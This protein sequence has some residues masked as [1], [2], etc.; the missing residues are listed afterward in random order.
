MDTTLDLAAL[1]YNECPD[2]PGWVRCE[3][4]RSKVYAGRG[5]KLVDLARHEERCKWRG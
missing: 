5:E 1:H 4:C 2:D 3:Y